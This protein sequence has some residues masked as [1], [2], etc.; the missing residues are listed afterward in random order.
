MEKIGWRPF[1]RRDWNG[2]KYVAAL[3]FAEGGGVEGRTAGAGEEWKFRKELKRVGGHKGGGRKEKVCGAR[4][5]K[6]KDI[7]LNFSTLSAWKRGDS[8]TN[9]KPKKTLSA[10]DGEKSRWGVSGGLA[11]SAPQNLIKT[12]SVKKKK[13]SLWR[14]QTNAASLS[15]RGSLKRKRN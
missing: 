12:Q 6:L 4:Y 3:Q 8:A 13:R 15:R 11:L 2:V 7:S 5:A 1:G 9:R 14:L 10:R